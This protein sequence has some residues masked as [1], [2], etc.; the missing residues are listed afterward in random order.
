ALAESHL[1]VKGFGYGPEGGQA[2][3]LSL[4]SGENTGLPHPQKLPFIWVSPV[5]T[6]I[7]DGSLLYEFEITIG[8]LSGDNPV[9]N[10]EVESDTLL[11]CLD[12]VSKLSDE[13]YPWSL[14]KQ[15]AI[16]PF[17]SQGSSNYTGHRMN[18]SLEFPFNYDY[19]M[20]PT[21]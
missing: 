5:I 15:S 19:C 12:I 11:I 14:V 2:T 4:Q 9:N 17:F 7:S 6:K 10:L 18:I 8:D 3:G 13:S 21:E 16:Q 1:Q 20:A